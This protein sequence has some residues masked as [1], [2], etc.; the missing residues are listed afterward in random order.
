IN[1][2]KENP[3]DFIKFKGP[4]AEGID[5]CNRGK[6]TIKYFNLN[7]KEEKGINSIYELRKG[8]FD[9]LNVNHEALNII[10]VNNPLYKKIVECI[11]KAKNHNE[12]YS[13]MVIDNFPI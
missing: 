8:L 13:A 5:K 7:R 2:Y 1:P 9:K 12:E 3:S 6:L 11:E 4:L 10:P